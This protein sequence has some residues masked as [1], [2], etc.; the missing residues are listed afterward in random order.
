MEFVRLTIDSSELSGI[1]DLP[2]SLRDRQVDVIILPAEHGT[3]QPKK[4]RRQLGFV[5]VPPLPESFFDPL[6]EDEL[7]AWGL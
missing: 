1:I 4:T 3:T 2:L 5:N 6:L 7:R